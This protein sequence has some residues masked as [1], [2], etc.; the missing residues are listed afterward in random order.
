MSS[1][2]MEVEPKTGV[3]F[4]VKLADGK[5]L[6]AT[7]LRKKKIVGV[8][9]N[10]YAFGIYADNAKLKEI[11]TAEISKAPK[12]P[13]KELYEIVINNDIPMVVRM[14]IIFKHLTIRM[15]KKNFEES[16]AVI[17]KK[18]SGEKNEELVSKVWEGANTDGIKL[19]AGSIIEI[20]RLPGH[21]YQTKFNDEV[22]SEVESELLCRAFFVQYFG[23]EPFDEEAKQKFGQSALSLLV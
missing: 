18:L 20:S 9:V 14:V 19:S 17:V 22:V 21:I 3:A 23:E 4:P 13:T 8:D 15:V 2:N 12:E 1:E 6:H 7:G 5:Q 16:L 11:L 10:M